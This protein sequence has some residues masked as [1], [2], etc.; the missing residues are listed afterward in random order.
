MDA[1]KNGL[2][3]H[4]SLDR[5]STQVRYGLFVNALKAQKSEV[6]DKEFCINNLGMNAL[7]ISWVPLLVFVFQN[8][9]LHSKAQ[10]MLSA[11]L[12]ALDLSPMEHPAAFQ[13]PVIL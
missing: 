4:A 9:H 10:Y 5:R 6:N 13:Q 2:L 7:S 3:D 8:L 1:T 12:V 11:E